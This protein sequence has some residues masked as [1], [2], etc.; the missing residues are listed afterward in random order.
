[1][2]FRPT[3]HERSLQARLQHTPQHRMLQGGCASKSAECL[4]QRSPNLPCRAPGGR[5]GVK[6]VRSS[7]ALGVPYPCGATCA[8]M[9]Q[10]W[11][12]I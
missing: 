10:L 7:P 4:E 3:L 2:E 11:L 6:W 1:M 5:M 9:A 12:H 8:H